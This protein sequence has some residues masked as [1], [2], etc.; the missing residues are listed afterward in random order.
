MLLQNEHP[1][2]GGVARIKRMWPRDEP[3]VRPMDIAKEFTDTELGNDYLASPEE[4]REL[5][6]WE[7]N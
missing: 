1:A 4:I 5:F 3:A 6:R 7:L 2:F